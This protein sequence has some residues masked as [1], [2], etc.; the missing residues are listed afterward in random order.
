MQ[1]IQSYLYPNRIIL[2]AD[3][4]GFTVENK[5]VYTR[6]VKIYQGVNNVIE[7]DI[8]NADQKRITLGGA[9]LNSLKVYV[10]DGSGKQL[11]T[12]PYTVTAMDQSTHKGLATVTIPKADI[13]GLI[14]QF[15][16]YSVVDSTSNSVLYN[17]SRFSAL[18]TMELLENITGTSKEDIVYD[19]FQGEINFM[20]NVINHTSATPCKFYEASPT[21]V[22]N[23]TVSMTGFIG[24]LYVEATED[25]TISVESFRDADRLQSHS[26]TTPY[27]GTYVFPN[28]PVDKYNYMRVSW[29]YPNISPYNFTNPNPYG[30][31]D[32]VTVNR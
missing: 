7:F 21:T 19:R 25:S 24:T 2:I 10:M 27:T 13:N 28:V 22:M 3:L 26:W 8:Q 4:A 5:I 23:F 18:G 29:V 32:Q 30:T 1:K 15:L 31:V 11:A 16:K 6:T 14:P 9:G 20:G 17:D 12:S